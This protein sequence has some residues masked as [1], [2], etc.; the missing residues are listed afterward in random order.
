MKNLKIYVERC[1][2]M[3]LNIFKIERLK[4]G[5]ERYSIWNE[6]NPQ[7]KVFKPATEPF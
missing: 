2:E 1:G 6:S 7:Y 5:Q 4:I 3:N